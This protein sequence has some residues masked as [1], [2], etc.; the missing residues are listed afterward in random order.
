VV[1]FFDRARHGEALALGAADH[2][3]RGDFLGAFRLADRLCRV[4]PAQALD[5]LLRSEAA[6]GA[7]LDARAAADLA[8][9][10]EL[11]PTQRTVLRF[12]LA[13][14]APEDRRAA[15]RALLEDPAADPE[16]LRRAVAELLVGAA[17]AIL[18]LRPLGARLE[19]WAA[20]RAG[21]APTCV[22]RCA[23]AESVA[24][25]A[26]AP[27]HF[28]LQTGV[29][30][31]A[32]SFDAAGLR[33]VAL[34]DGAREIAAWSPPPAPPPLPR[35]PETA[36]L[37]VIVP[38]Y[39]D[40]EATRACLNAAMA[41]LED[42]A[43]V[44]V[45]DDAS[46]NARL[47]AWL[48]VVAAS[49]R[50]EL[51][52]NPHNLGFAASVNRALRLCL[53][54]DVILLNADALPPHGAFARLAALA[55]ANP[56][57]G[58]VTPLS[59]NGETCSFPAP[60]ASS[61]LPDEDEIARL[62]ALARRAN[63]DLLVDLPN[64]IGFCLY[65][66]RACLDAT[67]P[68][69]EIYGRGYYE[70]VEFC[71]K[72]REKGFRTVCAAGVYVGHAGSLSFGAD[73]RRLVMRN[74][75]FLRARFPE[76]EAE[77]A[78]FLR[79]DP[80]RAARGAIEKL[81]PPRRP[82]RLVVAAAGA[83]AVAVRAL[84]RDPAEGAPLLCLYDP[85]GR[86]A[87]LRGPAGFA[88]QSLEFDLSAPLGLDALG[89]WLF[90]LRLSGVTLFYAPTLPDAL[91]AMLPAL[92]EVELA[93]AGLDLFAPPPHGPDDCLRP[94]DAKPC[95]ACAEGFAA[96]REMTA[97]LRAW[98]SAAHASARLRPLDRMSAHVAKRLFPEAVILAPPAPA[99]G[100][101]DEG[102]GRTLGV[103]SPHPGAET[104][105]LVLALAHALR[106]RDDPVDIVV[107]GVCLDDLAVMAP[108]NV[109][110]TGPVDDD[111]LAP[112]V[113]SYGVTELM[114]GSR[115]FAGRLDALSA[116]C[117]LPRAG[118][119]WSSG[120]LRFAA[121]ELALD[122]RLCDRKA[123]E[124]VADWLATRRACDPRRAQRTQE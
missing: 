20:W 80:L 38:V 49:G 25:L 116:A 35:A 62:D 66:T 12:V 115:A 73:K 123:A 48:D 31:T 74:M 107:F 77:C 47:R 36:K 63:G 95:A 27:D 69:P 96:S 32:L 60:N 3:R 28:L 45:V 24:G 10:F 18:L 53:G 22:A 102:G 103:L 72:A 42:G 83:S 86:K 90:R 108:G 39:E 70:D 99:P 23:D 71:L 15:A 78:A 76:H 101:F 88:P 85:V 75:E 54:G 117:R 58:A 56:D 57:V 64:G 5:V 121:G 13:W 92:G 112:L 122:P 9:A 61:P 34:R 93:I 7:G 65:I 17:E 114:A 91:V 120:A 43:R 29:E 37:W 52:R 84:T 30:S 94:G 21:Q 118:F 26:P 50:I 113:E 46:P 104:D 44:V 6:R 97:R 19:G 79:A 110:V 106:R 100:R 82:F 51:I 68:L 4:T 105:G 109:L 81:D 111:E 14:G 1:L 8:R 16:F 119:D 67:G 59:N 41:Q 98:R 124:H 40:F 87:Q 33:G 55:R 89:K 11:D 2:L